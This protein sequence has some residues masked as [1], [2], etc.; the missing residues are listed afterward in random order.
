MTAVD[1]GTVVIS[2][3]GR[4]YGYY[5]VLYHQNGLFSLYSHTL[6]KSRAKVGQVLNR[7]DTLAYMGRSGNAR[8]YH[9]HFELIDLRESWDFEASINEFVQAVAA[10]RSLSAY[11][12]EQFKQLLFAKKTK[13]DPLQ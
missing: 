9:L 8:G 7:G 6:K 12:C 13:Q 11:T 2:S 1:D 5:V 4:G 3:W 10:G